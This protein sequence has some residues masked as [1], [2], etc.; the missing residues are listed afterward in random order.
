[1]VQV[2]HQKTCTNN[3]SLCEKVLG[4][5]KSVRFFNPSRWA[6]DVVTINCFRVYHRLAVP[7]N[8]RRALPVCSS[9]ENS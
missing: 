2:V 5:E 8:Y 7:D 1:V 9:K 6:P 4:K 3:K